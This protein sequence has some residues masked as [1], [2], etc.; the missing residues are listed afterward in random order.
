MR[1]AIVANVAVMKS[2]QYSNMFSS[3]GYCIL[4][5]NNRKNDLSN[6]L[7]VGHGMSFEFKIH[8]LV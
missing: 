3:V 7:H 8:S 4:F 2:N 5:D 6:N 1:K